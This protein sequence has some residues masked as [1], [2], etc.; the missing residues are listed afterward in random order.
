LL[1]LLSATIFALA[2]SGLAFLERQTAMSRR[3]NFGSGLPHPGTI[4]YVLQA[5]DA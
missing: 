1:V 4:M 3:R 2:P 5:L